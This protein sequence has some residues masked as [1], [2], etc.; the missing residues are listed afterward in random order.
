MAVSTEETR[1]RA[2]DVYI[3]D[4]RTEI[5]PSPRWV[6]VR[7]GGQFVADS[8]NVLLLRETGHV[9]IYY[10][11]QADVH[12]D[13]LV[14]SD[15]TTSCPRKGDAVYWHVRVGDRTAEDAAWSYPRAPA[16]GPALAGHVAFDW[17]KM[18]AWFEEDGRPVQPGPPD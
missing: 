4:P 10:F 1:R 13:L 5:E 11:P 12:M 14:P 17:P 18:D 8:R 16:D 7:F 15:R 3:P 6:R 9:P 2:G